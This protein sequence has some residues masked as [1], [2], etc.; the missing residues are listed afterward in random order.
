[1]NKIEPP[2]VNRF[3]SADQQCR[4]KYGYATK[5][6][7]KYYARMNRRRSTVY[8]CVLCGQWHLASRRPAA[9]GT[10]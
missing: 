2:A 5:R 3:G 10:R 1:M 4:R 7:A 9:G 8:R 6:E